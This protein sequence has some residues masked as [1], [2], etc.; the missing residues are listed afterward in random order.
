MQ[1]L[2]ES[3]QNLLLA[4]CNFSIWKSF[5]ILISLINGV[6]YDTNSNSKCVCAHAHTHTLTHTHMRTQ[7]LPCS[8]L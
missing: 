5:K 6:L 3:L 1:Q 4:F 7:I 2:H 8:S